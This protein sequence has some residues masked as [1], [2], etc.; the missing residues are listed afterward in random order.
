MAWRGSGVRIPSAPPRGLHV[1]V[2][3]LFTF[4]PWVIFASGSDIPGVFVVVRG[5]G[6]GLWRCCGEGGEW[7]AAP[8]AGPR[9]EAGRGAAGV[10]FLAPV[11][12][13][14]DA[15]VAGDGQAGG[16]QQAGGQAHDAAPAAGDVAGG[17]VLEGGE[18]A[19]GAGAACV[20]AAVRGGG[21]VVFLRGLGGD[22][23]RDGEGLL[24]A[25]GGRVR[26]RG[27]DLGAVPVQCQ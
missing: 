20:G 10:I 9:G 21:V 11:P 26:G 5:A 19:F 17:G 14:G 13:G 25:A 18:A 3:T 27:E 6:C 8:A 1:S 4:G 22:L 24:G 12:G 16:E 2:R 23:G 15:L 7:F